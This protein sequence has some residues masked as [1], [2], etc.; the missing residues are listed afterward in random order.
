[1]QTLHFIFHFYDHLETIGIGAA[2]FGWNTT[3]ETFMRL[4][5]TQWR[6]ATLCHHLCI[7]YFITQLDYTIFTSQRRS[8]Y[9]QPSGGQ[10]SRYDGH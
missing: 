5:T 1:M 4:G 2:H 10:D 9:T 8:Y 3:L 7:T 6:L